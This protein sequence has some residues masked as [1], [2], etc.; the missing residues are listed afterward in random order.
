MARKFDEK[1][2]VVLDCEKKN[3]LVSAGAGS[4]KTTVMIKKITDIILSGKAKPSQLIV[5]TFT[6]LA[7][8]EMKQR[9]T[10]A[11]SS[12][13]NNASTEEQYKHISGLL[14]EID[15]SS[16]DTIDGF[17]S[18]MTKKYF[19]KLNLSPE[20]N[21]A[22]GLS[23]DYYRNKSLDQCIESSLTLNRDEV[24]NLADCFEKTAR[25][26]D[27]LKANLL[28]AF[29]FVMAQADYDKFIEDAVNEYSGLN[30]SAN[31]LNSHL[32]Q[33]A[34]DNISIIK[35][36]INDL[37][38][39]ENFFNSVNNYLSVLSQITS[40]KTILENVK[41]FSLLPKIGINRIKD[42][43]KYS[44]EKVK[45]ALK[46][47]STLVDDYS[48]I[49][50]FNQDYFNNNIKHFNTF[51]SLLK[52]FIKTYQEMKEK[53]KVLDFA[54]L[55]RNLLKLLTFEDVKNDIYSDYKYIFVDEYQDINPMQNEIILKLKSDNTNIF[56]VGDVKQSIYG[57]RQSTPELFLKMYEE[58][59][60][61]PQSQSF[62]M[63]INFRS[64]PQILQFNNIIFNKLMTKEKTDIDYYNESQ[65]E[66][67]RTDF[68]T[69][70]DNIE[71]AIFN[72]NSID[73][74]FATGIYS[75]QGDQSINT[76]S[77]T[78]QESEF[79][80]D[81]IISLVG[82]DF[83]DSSLKQK[84][85][86]TFN[87]V[88]I[89]SRSVNDNKNNTLI[90]VLRS[91]NIPVNIV[92]KVELNN[93]ESLNL[94][95]NILKVLAN[96]GDDTAYATYLTSNLV[97]MTFDEMFEISS[98]VNEKT[99]FLKLIFYKDNFNNAIS[100]KIKYAFNLLEEIK[101]ESATLNNL[102]LIDL[103]LNHY[104]IKQ[105]ILNSPNGKNEYISL[106]NFLSTISNKESIL[107][108][109]EFIAYIEVNMSNK[110]EYSQTDAIDSVTIQTI[111]A[112]KG[113]EYPVVILFNSNKKFKPNNDRDDINFDGELG[114]GM[115][116]FD[117]EKRTK[118][119]SL[120]RFAIN[121][122][123]KI[124]CYKEEVRLLYVATTRP[125]NKLII[126]GCV[127]FDNIRNGKIATNNFIELIYSVFENNLDIENEVTILPSCKF[128]QFVD[129]NSSN[130][131]VKT[132]NSSSFSV[133]SKNLDFTYPNLELCNI[134]LKN[135][136][137]GISKQQNEEY[138]ILPNKL[139]INENLDAKIQSSAELGTLYHKYLSEID[140]TKEYKKVNTN[141]VDESLLQ[142]A[143]SKLYD[144]C[145]N[146]INIKHENQFM[147][148]VP[149]NQI[150]KDSSINQKVL[151]QGVV[152]LMVEF[153]DH[154]VLIDFKFS[155]RDIN[156][157][158]ERY[159]TQLDLYK[160]AIEKAY[161]KPVTE[162]Y[163]YKIN[164]GEII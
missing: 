68:D 14:E 155:K 147:M 130:L 65:F 109:E 131:S 59:K 30:K 94:I 40:T 88:T 44:Y 142:L 93:C 148:Y 61:N 42:E 154:F 43:D 126:T 144:I 16:V 114:I 133:N 5:L 12:E 29:Y 117:L 51:I 6:N 113:L 120:T 28:N 2:Q 158:Q 74:L 127:K 87:D 31:F 125:Q 137:T 119:D 38:H 162:S 10:T 13:L 160:M 83:Y 121:V 46:N 75:V 108:F 140:F 98:S 89:L 161:H 163:I 81:K 106:N 141:E 104:H 48:F 145:R 79:I 118:T 123:N 73:Q 67:K 7:A 122:K 85:K 124:K 36:Y 24:I 138:N 128:Y 134:S 86:M 105:Y 157:L 97:N 52:N 78:E 25:N 99:F 63:N 143:H 102:G 136:V 156:T 21:I 164:S 72:D 116:Y 71:I 1:Q 17:C 26:L 47:I 57:F 77:C 58:Y 23:L 32:L 11:L 91:R 100:E 111:H 33:T 9:L 60:S 150:F 135:N 84:R 112:S 80:A 66:P 37:S 34:S 45:D 152:D 54:D 110:T 15:T 70:D 20:I 22:T 76:K 101:I 159:K 55:E 96:I 149:Y 132:K 49:N 151:V 82:T 95:L 56:F 92:N 18:K 62:D 50:N 90:K 39:Y 115:Q 129:Y 19:Y 153:P 3:Q 69:A 53:Y 107:S 27:A 64:N 139:N 4:G 146:C 41:T 103:L 35:D 8:G